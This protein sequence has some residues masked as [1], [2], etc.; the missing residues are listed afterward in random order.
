MYYTYAWQ[1]LPQAATHHLMDTWRTFQTIFRPRGEFA[2]PQGTGW[3]LHGL[4]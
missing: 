2:Y 4:T 3:E 1:P